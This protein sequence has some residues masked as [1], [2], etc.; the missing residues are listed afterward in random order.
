[1]WN[2]EMLAALELAQGPLDFPGQKRRPTSSEAV[3]IVTRPFALL[4]KRSVALLRFRRRV[5]VRC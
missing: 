3:R 2:L 4:V 1:M 5:W